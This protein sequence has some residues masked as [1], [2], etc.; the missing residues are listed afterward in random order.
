MLKIILIITG[1]ILYTSI[2]VGI[3]IWSCDHSGVK[4][5][6]DIGGLLI[7]MILWPVFIL[8]SIICIFIEYFLE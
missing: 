7:F 1:L 4:F 5:H 6:P 3:A 2:G 8:G